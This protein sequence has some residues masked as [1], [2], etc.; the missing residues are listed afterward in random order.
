ME[1]TDTY[2]AICISYFSTVPKMCLKTKN[3][4]QTRSDQLTAGQE[5]SCPAIPLFYFSA[6]Y[7]VISFFRYSYLSFACASDISNNLA[8]FSGLER[9]REL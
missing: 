5:H 3:N 8:A 6:L 2:C 1:I 4:F 7:K 9:F